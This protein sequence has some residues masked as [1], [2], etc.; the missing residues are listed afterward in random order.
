MS[1]IA[2]SPMRCISAL[3]SVDLVY[4][5][6]DEV[7]QAYILSNDTSLPR[8]QLFGVQRVTLTP[9][10]QSFS[11]ARSRK[12]F[13]DRGSKATDCF[14]GRPVRRGYLYRTC[15]YVRS[16]WRPRV[17][18]CSSGNSSSANSKSLAPNAYI[19]CSREGLVQIHRA[20]LELSFS[21]T[22]HRTQTN[23]GDQVV[24]VTVKLVGS[25]RVVRPPYGKRERTRRQ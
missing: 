9:G 24:T 10:R 23:G 13:H 19:L 5:V 8:K 11:Q 20:C 7:V 4:A 22:L 17:E 6:G 18:N 1:A 25:S 15:R 2:V 21:S 16:C 14:V 12:R 3:I